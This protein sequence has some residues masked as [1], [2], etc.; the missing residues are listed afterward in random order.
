MLL[1]RLAQILCFHDWG[2]PI[3]RRSICYKCGAEK[4]LSS[5]LDL[6]VEAHRLRAEKA[7]QT[8]IQLQSNMRD[9]RT[10]VVSIENR[11]NSQAR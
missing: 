6:N 9:Q 8:L 5:S 4:V 2:V 7:R 11:K 10:V 1:V 3:R